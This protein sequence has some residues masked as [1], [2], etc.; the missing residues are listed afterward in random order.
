MKITLET[1][2]DGFEAVAEWRLPKRGEQIIRES[3]RVVTAACDYDDHV[4]D[5]QIVLTR[6]KNKFWRL[7]TVAS[8]E[9][10]TVY[11]PTKENGTNYR[12]AIDKNCNV[13]WLTRQCLP[14]GT[15]WL[16]RT[17]CEE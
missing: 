17:E 3:G 9:D 4:H 16:R 13:L 1:P 2:P 10:A 5:F 7:D 14:T 15:R 12:L 11:D 8:F 6:K